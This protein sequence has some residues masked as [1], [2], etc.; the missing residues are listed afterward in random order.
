ML[1]R[2][3]TG[4]ITGDG[5]IK[6]VGGLDPETGQGIASDHWHQGAVG[7]EAEVD[8]GTG[9]VYLRRLHA[10]AYAGRV[11]NPKMA[12]LQMHG[13]VFFGIGHALYEEMVFEDGILTNP[14][15]SDYALV[16]MGDVPPSSRWSCSRTRAAHT[17]TA[18]VKPCSRRSSRPSATP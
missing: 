17:S 5:E 9:K 8:L 6:T 18:S 12:R 15:L 11:V 3:R 16:A 1:Y 10:I 4:S 14:N 7:V 13:S 2:T